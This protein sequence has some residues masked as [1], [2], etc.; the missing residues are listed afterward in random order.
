[1]TK[2]TISSESINNTGCENTLEN[3]K[4]VKTVLMLS[5]L[6]YHCVIHW[7]C[8]SN[9]RGIPKIKSEVLSIFTDWLGSF[10]IYA[11]TLVSGYIFAYKIWKLGGVLII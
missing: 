2:N 5:V 1:M 4:F 3:C 6:I 11:F 10:H 7:R 9:W 8:G